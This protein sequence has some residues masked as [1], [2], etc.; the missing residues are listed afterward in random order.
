VETRGKETDQSIRRIRASPALLLTHQRTITLL[1]PLTRLSLFYSLLPPNHAARKPTAALDPR[2]RPLL[3]RLRPSAYES[4]YEKH[5]RLEREIE[6]KRISDRIDDE[7]RRDKERFKRTKQDVKV[8]TRSEGENPLSNESG[9]IPASF[10]CSAR[11]S[12]ASPPSRNSSSSS[13]LQP[14]STLSALP[15]RL[16]YFTTWSMQSGASSTDSNTGAISF[17]KTSTNLG[18]IPQR[19]AIHTPP[20]PFLHYTTTAPTYCPRRRRAGSR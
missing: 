11:L 6:A 13:T 14:H 9:T 19:R 7:I 12:R 3:S 5:A 1:I 10:C 18:R 8:S 20:R 4:D 2:R 17:T 16:L 15:G